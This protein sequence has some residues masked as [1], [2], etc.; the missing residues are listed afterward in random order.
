MVYTH[1]S[2]WLAGALA[3]VL[4]LVMLS[5][6]AMVAAQAK[7]QTFVT[8]G[9][10]GVT[11]IYYPLGGA[12]CRLVNKVRKETGV[13][14]AVESTGGSIT[15]VKG[16]RAGELDLGVVQSDVQFHAVEGTGPFADAGKY[17]D[18]RSL[19]SVHAEPFTVVAS[20]ASNIRSIADLPGKRVNIG[21][22]GS[23]QRQTMEV[24]MEAFGWTPETF[25][26]VTEL[27]ASDHSQALC[28]GEIDAFVFTVGHPSAS[29]KEAT[30]GCD[31]VIVAVEGPEIDGIVSENRFFSK[32][33][34]PGGLYR[35]NGEDV[36]TFA[37]TATVVTSDAT[38]A[39]TTYAITKAVF[40][41]LEEFRRLHP[42]FLELKPADM[43]SRGLTAPP[44]EG[45]A[46]FFSEAG[47]R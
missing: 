9:T 29:I 11:G 20:K 5:V 23:G 19:F 8:V 10:G 47:L 33:V 1:I 25:A 44:H 21:N 6:P 13:R 32:T 38:S 17:E 22:P 12:I 15:N 36:P 46:R 27:P 41:Q 31:S 4:A 16:L 43:V 26:E 30:T 2:R 24:V 3:M 7:T 45:A 14:C 35:G 40:E 39:D 28:D 42:V 18:L 37:L 34:V